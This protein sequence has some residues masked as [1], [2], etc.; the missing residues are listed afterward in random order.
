MGGWNLG[1][2]QTGEP[3]MF[4]YPGWANIPSSNASSNYTRRGGNAV[5][6][7]T[8]IMVVGPGGV[9]A[10]WTGPRGKSVGITPLVYDPSSGPEAGLG[11]ATE[12]EQGRSG[13]FSP[14]SN[15]WP[16]A[17]V[18]DETDTSAP[19]RL[20]HNFSPGEYTP[21]DAFAEEIL[22]TKWNNRFDI[23]ITRKVHNWAHQMF[24]GFRYCGIYA[25]KRRR[26]AA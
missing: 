17:D 13:S 15:Y 1:S 12:W 19:P 16:D 22:I 6:F 20:I 7:G 5:G 18:P 23:T 26:H 4:W 25:G 11:A 2:G 24:D 10:A 3:D 21:D 8:W 9:D 14:S